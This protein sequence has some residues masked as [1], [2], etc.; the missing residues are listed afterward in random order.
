MINSLLSN[1][2]VRCLVRFFIKTNNL[3][4]NHMHDN[5][6]WWYTW[7][8]SIVEWEPIKAIDKVK[9][10][11]FEWILNEKVLKFWDHN[12]NMITSHCMISILRM[13]CNSMTVSVQKLITYRQ[14]MF[15]KLTLVQVPHKR[16]S[17][18]FTWG[19]WSTLD[20][21][22]TPS[23]LYIYKATNSYFRY[24]KNTTN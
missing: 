15:T 20:I 18:P 11:F 24:Q 23:V 6:F 10:Y 8:I 1:P 16:T 19:Y 17:F 3:Y 4:M 5:K 22:N 12:S 2:Q 7:N 14:K 9:C 21:I 13:R